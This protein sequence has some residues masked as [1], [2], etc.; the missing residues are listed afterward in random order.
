M[1]TI[2]RA[3]AINLLVDLSLD[4]DDGEVFDFPNMTNDDLLEELCLSGIFH[5]EDLD[6]VV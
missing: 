2:T 3:E 1:K 5:D 4:D 6:A